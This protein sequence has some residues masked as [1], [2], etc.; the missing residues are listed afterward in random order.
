MATPTDR[1]EANRWLIAVAPFALFAAVVIVWMAIDRFVTLGPL[2]RAQLGWLV[3]VPLTIAIPVVAAWAGRQLGRSWRPAIALGLG[4]VGGFA[5]AWPFW[6]SYA[7]Q[8]AAVGLPMPI[9]G[10]AFVGA[11]AGI[12]LGAAVLAAG[13]AFDRARP[14]LAVPAAA[15]AAVV[16]F[17]IGFAIFALS[18][19]QLF[20]G[21]CVVR[22]S[23]TP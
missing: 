4:L 15:L 8:C 13:A 2:D 16:V 22:P 9:G 7:S 21:T 19:M 17:A 23:I 20:F 5:V 1:R 6:V 11:T 12:S 18:V 10:I 14:A 3:A